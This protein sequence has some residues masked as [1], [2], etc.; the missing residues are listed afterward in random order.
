MWN[1]DVIGCRLINRMRWAGHVAYNFF[2]LERLEGRDQPEDL[3]IDGR[4]ILK[5]ILRI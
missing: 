1:I 2:L 4:I 3:G 5:F